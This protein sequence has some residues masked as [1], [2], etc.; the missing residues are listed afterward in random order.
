M[1]NLDSD[2]GHYWLSINNDTTYVYRVKVALGLGQS[3]YAIDRN[4]IDH[5]VYWRRVET[6]GKFLLKI[7]NCRL[8]KDHNCHNIMN[9]RRS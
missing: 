2:N 6:E 8:M 7:V 4:G 9:S 1:G 5:I 3:S